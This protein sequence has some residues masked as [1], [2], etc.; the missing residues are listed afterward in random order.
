LQLQNFIF[1]YTPYEDLSG[2][3]EIEI[4]D[5]PPNEKQDFMQHAYLENVTTSLH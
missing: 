3:F 2:K 4:E 5:S 1:S